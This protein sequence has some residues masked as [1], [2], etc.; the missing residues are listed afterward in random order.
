MIS[1]RLTDSSKRTL[2]LD[3]PVAFGLV[4][5]LVFF[6]ISGAVAYLNLQILREGNRS[7]TH[8]HDVIVALDRLLSNAQDAETGQRG[9]LLTNDEKYLEPYNAAVRAIPAMLDEIGQLTSDSP[10]QQARVA[11][12]RRRVEAKLVELRETIERR[13]TQGPD[14]ALA[15]VNSDRGKAAMDAVRAQLSA[16][17]GKRRGFAPS[18]SPTWTVPRRPLSPPVSFP[19]SSASC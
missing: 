7:V 19:V 5:A 18:G 15:I 14:A 13:R 10:A 17:A 2:G 12:L 11:E 9:F 1:S 3:P 6:L 8:S 16:M 4:A